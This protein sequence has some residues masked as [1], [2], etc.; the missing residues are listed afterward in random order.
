M[1]FNRQSS[2]YR[3][4]VSRAKLVGLLTLTAVVVVGLVVT[5]QWL[6]RPQRLPV[7]QTASDRNTIRHMQLS[8]LANAVTSYIES[9]GALPIKLPTEA[10]EICSSL[11]TPC[12]TAHLL[13]LNFL[14]TGSTELG[15]IPA[16]PIG[17]SVR[18]GTGYM[19]KLNPQSH[20][21]EL[22]AP[23][24]ENGSHIT[25]HRTLP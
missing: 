11:G 5:V 24:A 7:A 18:Y 16:D 14:A 12:R 13:D 6:N 10:T 4:H 22:W 19:I 17:S 2:L 1:K 20:Q 9:R 23:R 21:L 15:N 8:A 25:V 3:G